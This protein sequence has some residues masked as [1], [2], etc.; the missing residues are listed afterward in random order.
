MIEVVDYV[1][2]N[3]TPILFRERETGRFGLK[4]H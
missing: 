1:L 2:L 3:L 4:S